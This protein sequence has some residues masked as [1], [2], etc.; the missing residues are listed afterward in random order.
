M[1]FASGGICTRTIISDN[2]TIDSDIC[3]DGL[4]ISDSYDYDIDE[5][6][7]LGV[8]MSLGLSFNISGEIFLT[9][10]IHYS[11]LFVTPSY[12]SYRSAGLTIGANF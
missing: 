8:I 4:V 9:T 2:S 7:S 10:A 1:P 3:S 6:T 5:K 11:E 12:G